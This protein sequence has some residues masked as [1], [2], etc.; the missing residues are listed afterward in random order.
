MDV[1]TKT[2]RGGFLFG[3]KVN[4]RSKPKGGLILETVDL[5][6]LLYHIGLDL[7]AVSHGD[8][9]QCRAWIIH[10]GAYICL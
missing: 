7:Y 8:C 3:W 5:C 6:S 2:K 9:S 4:L 10:I 1:S